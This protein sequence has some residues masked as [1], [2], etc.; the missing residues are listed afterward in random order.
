MY[1][2]ISSDDY[3]LYLQRETEEAEDKKKGSGKLSVTMKRSRAAAIHNQSE[4]VSSSFSSAILCKI[5]YIYLLLDFRKI[6]SLIF[7]K[8]YINFG[9]FRI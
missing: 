2:K 9:S 4:R 8:I 3:Y 1:I 6:S 7:L 5:S